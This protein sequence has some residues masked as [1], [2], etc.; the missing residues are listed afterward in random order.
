MGTE[1]LSGGCM[2]FVLQFSMLPY[3]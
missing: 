3:I 2:Q 1:Q